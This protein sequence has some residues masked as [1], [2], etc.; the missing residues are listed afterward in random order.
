MLQ[1]TIDVDVEFA[2]VECGKS[3]DLNALCLRSAI[4]P[5]AIFLD[6]A[7]RQVHAVIVGYT[8]QVHLA[9]ASLHRFAYGGRAHTL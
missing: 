6:S 8:L 3:C 5:D 4:P 9:P 1:L 7:V 2:V